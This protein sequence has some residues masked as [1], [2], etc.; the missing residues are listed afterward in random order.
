MNFDQPIV[1]SAEAPEAPDT[2]PAGASNGGA[3]N[4]EAACAADAAREARRVKR[5]A[6]L[7]LVRDANVETVVQLRQYMTGELE[8]KAAEIFARVAD[9]C[10]ALARLTRLVQQIVTLEDKL[11]QD[12]E[13]RALTLKKEAEAR[14]AEARQAEAW[15][16]GAPDRQAREEAEEEQAAKKHAIR[17]AVRNAH[18][19]NWPDTAVSTREAQLDAMFR[20][21]EEY[22]DYEG[23]PEEI[24]TQLCAELGLSPIIESMP[25]ATRAEIERREARPAAGPF[26]GMSAAACEEYR[27]TQ[28]RPGA[29]R[30]SGRG[31][32]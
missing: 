1:A 17:R 22:D 28:A 5:L 2:A 29:S 10:L 32:P 20:D 23:D 16:A 8:D 31:P 19:E 25:D 15:R 12:D 3:P 7:E 24:V 30:G 27:R 26:P 6:A 9:P 4:G 14:Q 11:D 13:T 21:Y 18:K